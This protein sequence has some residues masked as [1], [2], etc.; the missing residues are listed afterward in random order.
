MSKPSPTR[1]LFWQAA[2][3]REIFTLNTEQLATQAALGMASWKTAP[4]SAAVSRLQ[5]EISGVKPD[6]IG[7]DRFPIMPGS[8]SRIWDFRYKQHGYYELCRA[9]FGFVNNEFARPT[10]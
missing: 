3:N 6:S 10:F 7:Q 4:A 2:N 1:E 8:M 9:D 5:R